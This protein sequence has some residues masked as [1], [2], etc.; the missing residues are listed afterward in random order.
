MKRFHLLLAVEAIAFAIALVTP[1]MPSRTGSEGNLAAYFIADPG[2]LEEALVY[3]GLVNVLI[4]VLGI[5]LWVYV[6]RAEGG[7]GT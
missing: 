5:V 7:N 2:Y 6:R 4:G 3:F 1:I